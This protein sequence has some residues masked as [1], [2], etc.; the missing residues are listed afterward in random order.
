MLLWSMSW[1]RCLYV[2]ESSSWVEHFPTSF[3]LIANH[4]YEERMKN[5]LT[6]DWDCVLWAQIPVRIV[7]ALS[8]KKGF[9]SSLAGMFNIHKFPLY[10]Y[11]SC[12]LCRLLWGP[13]VRVLHW[14]YSLSASSVACSLWRWLEVLKAWQQ[15]THPCLGNTM[16]AD[17]VGS[18]WLSIGFFLWQLQS[19][20]VSYILTLKMNMSCVQ[21]SWLIFRLNLLSKHH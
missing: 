16:N 2:H 20:V 21:N 14:A 17:V 4:F 11:R 8:E 3:V 7:G 19:S 1:R 18:F 10:F 13:E 15:E 9:G 12:S 5:C 6:A